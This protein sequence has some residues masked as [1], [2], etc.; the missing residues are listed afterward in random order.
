MKNNP[1]IVFPKKQTAEIQYREV[2]QPGPGE[3]LIKNHKS[4]ISIGTEM[5]AFSGDYPAAA[6][7]LVR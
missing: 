4:L 1:V 7:G 6:P 5:T 2:K 3:L